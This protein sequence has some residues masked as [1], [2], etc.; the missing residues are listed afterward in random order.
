LTTPVLPVG[1]IGLTSQTR[2]ANFGC[3]HVDF[4]FALVVCKELEK[5]NREF[6]DEYKKDRFGR[7][8]H[9]EESIF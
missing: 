1:P 5:E 3:E 9:P 4:V 8:V 2:R 7:R 6:F